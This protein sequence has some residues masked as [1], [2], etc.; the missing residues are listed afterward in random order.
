SAT[1]TGVAIGTASSTKGPLTPG[2]YGF[3]AMYV[4][5]SDA[6]HVNSGWSA[7][8][9]FSIAK[10]TP[11]TGTTLKNAAG[12]ATIAEGSALPIGSSVYDTA[13]VNAGD[14][15]PLTGTITFEFYGNATCSGTASSTQTGVAVGTASSAQGPL[16]TGSYGFRAMYV[17]GSDPNHADSGW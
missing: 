1:Q 5:G 2:S 11:S 14:A 12:N 6:N 4:A 13:S 3:R 16:A 8:E 7:C 10:G 17:A 15:L 9:P